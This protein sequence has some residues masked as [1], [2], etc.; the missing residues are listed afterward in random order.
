M[1]PVVYTSYDYG[2]AFDEARQIRPKATTMKELGLFLQSVEP[3]A[4]VDKGPAVTPSNSRIKVYSDVNTDTGTHFYI[5][6]HNPSS[7]TTNDAFTFTATTNDGTYQMPASGTLAVN[8]QDSKILVADY[9]MNSQHLVYS[10]SPIMTH[11]ETGGRD[12]ALLYAPTGED[13]ETV[14]RY[15]S[16]PTVDVLSGD[17]Q[18]VYDPATGDLRL[19]YV[20][21]GLAEVRI[22]G[23]GRA[24]LTLLLGPLAVAP[25][26]KSIGIGRRLVALAL[27][28]ARKA[29]AGLVVL[30]GDEPYYG[31]LG[32]TKIP[33]GQL[34]MPRPVDLHRLLAHEILPGSLAGFEGMV[35]HELRAHVPAAAGAIAARDAA[36]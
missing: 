6:V 5:A 35:T 7:A 17:V 31:P 15:A 23:G 8:G 11:F 33:P 30:V 3:I 10:T 16:Q 1:A 19:N 24:P 22:S 4:K 9:D 25:V 12:I 32:F 20:H 2:A 26:A 18:S 28:E 29:G 34:E 27:A 21:S 36:A 14:L 13:G